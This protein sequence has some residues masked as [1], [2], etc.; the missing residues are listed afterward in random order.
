MTILSTERWVIRL[1]CG[2]VSCIQS[3]TYIDIGALVPKLNAMENGWDL[4]LS[5]YHM[6]QKFGHK[7]NILVT[8]IIWSYQGMSLWWSFSTLKQPKFVLGHKIYTFL[9]TFFSNSGPLGLN[10]QPIPTWCALIMFTPARDF[11]L[12]TPWRIIIPNPNVNR[13]SLWSW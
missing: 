6:N 7:D 4:W 3:L 9:H 11:L 10:W 12:E 2:W 1:G 8:A 5:G 13:H